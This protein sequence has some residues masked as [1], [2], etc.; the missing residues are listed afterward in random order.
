LSILNALSLTLIRRQYS[1]E[2]RRRKEKKRKERR[3]EELARYRGSY[4]GEKGKGGESRLLPC[5]ISVAK[6]KKGGRKRSVSTD[7]ALGTR[8]FV[9]GRWKKGEERERERKE[10]IEGRQNVPW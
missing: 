4:L 1:Q 6:K 3:E 2:E 7:E 5:F 8:N 10:K 9:V